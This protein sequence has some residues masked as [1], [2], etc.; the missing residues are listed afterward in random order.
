[1]GTATKDCGCKTKKEGD[2][3]EERCD[4]A[5]EVCEQACEECGLKVSSWEEFNARQEFIEG[6]I[7]ENELANRAT[8]EVAHHAQVFGKY[9]VIDKEEPE[10]SSEESRR[11]DRARQANRIY[12]KVCDE[13]ELTLCF[14][15]DFSSWSDYVK[16]TLSDSELYD[17]AKDEAQ[18]LTGVQ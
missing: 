13:A 16:G 6:R 7:D 11:K 2:A 9:L 4:R 14:F 3:M 17:R 18:K 10:S 15:S 5:N 12:R 1:M 8:S